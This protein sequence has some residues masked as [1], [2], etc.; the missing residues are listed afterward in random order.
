MS[1]LQKLKGLVCGG[2]HGADG[3]GRTCLVH[4]V[5][6][7]GRSCGGNSDVGCGIRRV[8]HHSDPTTR[9]GMS[10]KRLFFMP[11]SSALCHSPFVIGMLLARS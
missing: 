5:R 10:P 1:G 6:V 11:D 7:C 8:A 3:S 9:Q 4:G 2:R